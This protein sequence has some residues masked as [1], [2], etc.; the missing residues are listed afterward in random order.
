[1]GAQASKTESIKN[2]LTLLIGQRTT[3]IT[4]AMVKGWKTVLMRVTERAKK[5]KAS[6]CT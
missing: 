3:Q 1:M 4:K 2:K 6:L 5:R